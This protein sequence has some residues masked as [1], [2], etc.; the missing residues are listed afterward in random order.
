MRKTIMPTASVRKDVPELRPLSYWLHP[1][2]K[3]AEAFSR[4]WYENQRLLP[5]LLEGFERRA[6]EDD[7]YEARALAREPEL[8][9]ILPHLR[10]R[11]RKLSELTA[12]ERLTPRW[13]RWANLESIMAPIGVQSSWQLR[14]GNDL[15]PT[16]KQQQRDLT[17]LSLIRTEPL[18]DS[19]LGLKLSSLPETLQRDIA[20][21]GLLGDST[22]F[23][24]IT[25]LVV[26]DGRDRL[27]HD[28][29][30]KTSSLSAY[31]PYAY[32]ALCNTTSQPDT[33]SWFKRQHSSLPIPSPPAAYTASFPERPPCKPRSVLSSVMGKTW[34]TFE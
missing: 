31:R 29:P 8:S 6:A 21:T 20:R 16:W 24:L 33:M 9:F 32:C 18:P 4:P 34:P 27:P 25:I 5:L 19:F 23:P 12:A 14:S 11:R 26:M 15:P 22:S 10:E 28:Y 1:Y 2:T 17:K 30:P 3:E 13:I 7:Q